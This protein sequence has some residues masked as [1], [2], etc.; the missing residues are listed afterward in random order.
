[1]IERTSA[2]SHAFRFVL[3]MG[4]VNLFADMTYSSISVA[5]GTAFNLRRSARVRINL[6]ADRHRPPDG[7]CGQARLLRHRPQRFRLQRVG[8]PVPVALLRLARR[9]KDAVLDN[10]VL[11][12]P[13]ACHHRGVL[14]FYYEIGSCTR[15][16]KSD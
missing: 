6:R 9:F 1:N 13:Q 2:A 8:V 4:V 5:W 16:P 14:P 12:G 15:P 11:R 7:G 10:A 3:T